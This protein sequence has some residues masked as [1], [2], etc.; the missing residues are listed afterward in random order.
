MNCSS[1]MRR[2]SASTWWG[3][4]RSWHG[5]VRRPAVRNYAVLVSRSETGTE[6][7]AHI[8]SKTTLSKECPV[9][10]S[11]ALNRRDVR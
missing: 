8:L 4:Q 9:H 10:R 7:E 3:N 6:E 5:R 2:T 1:P 11:K